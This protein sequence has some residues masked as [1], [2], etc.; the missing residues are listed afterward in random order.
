MT[1]S[2]Q[3]VIVIS[4]AEATLSRWR[5]LYK[6]LLDTSK[7]VFDYEQLMK[8]FKLQLFYH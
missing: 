2:Y 6:N 3:E 1:S 8:F 5:K 4:A 7:E